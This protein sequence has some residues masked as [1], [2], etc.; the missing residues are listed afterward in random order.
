MQQNPWIFF[1]G[2]F[3]GAGKT[4]AIH[5]LSKLLSQRGTKVAAITNDQAAGLVD[6]FF[7]SGEGIPAEEVAGSCFC[8]NFDG[9]TEAIDHSVQKAEPEIILAEPVGSCTDI[10]ATVIRPM[11][12]L[13]R[14]KVSVFGY[15]VLVEPD[16]WIELNHGENVPWSMKFLFDKQIEEA[17]ILVIT[18][19]DTRAQEELTRIRSDVESRFPHLK[20]FTVSARTGFGM[21]EW[22]DFVQNSVPGDRWLKEIDYQKYAEAEAEMGWL[23]A[24]ATIK[25]PIPVDG[26]AVAGKIAEEIRNQVSRRGGRVGHLKLLAV[27]KTGSIKAGITVSGEHLEVDGTF[28]GPLSELQLTVNI[29]A[30]VSPGD[31]S[32]IVN[33][34]LSLVKNTE[35]AEVDLSYVNTFRPSP[36]NPTHRYNT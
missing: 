27:G 3:L 2:G 12:H 8:C 28:T 19:A 15:S 22:L 31:L 9:L 10:V 14:D 26:M 34:T 16:R 30:A 20:V 13:M 4:T 18:K 24:Q 25:F 29:R 1:V 36:P 11:Q 5:V 7:L 6:T 33:S 32:E 17:D 21:E 35:N 23:N